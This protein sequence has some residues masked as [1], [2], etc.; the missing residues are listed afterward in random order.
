MIQPTRKI[1]KGAV[2]RRLIVIGIMVAGPAPAGAEEGLLSY[3]M[4]VIKDA[5][6]G[7]L[8][9]DGKYAAAITKN[10]EKR[11]QQDEFALSNNLCV[12][13]TLSREFDKARIACDSA[14]NGASSREVAQSGPI[15]SAGTKRRALDRY[16]AMA[17]SNRGVLKVVQ[18]DM[19]G[20]R[21]DFEA[22]AA[23]ETSVAAARNNLA[24]FEQGAQT[25]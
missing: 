11:V 15:I 7:H 4:T 21:L 19:E 24:R 12:A 5:A 9:V 3:E 6:N 17:F 1:G 23:L 22:A 2:L 13:Y 14:V 10:L 20:A 16:D 25:D 8:I 18:G